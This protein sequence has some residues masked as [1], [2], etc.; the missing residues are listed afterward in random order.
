MNIRDRL[1][2]LWDDIA[3]V[4]RNALQ[5]DDVIGTGLQINLEEGMSKV[6]PP[7]I[8]YRYEFDFSGGSTHV[9]FDRN[10]LSN[11]VRL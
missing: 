11:E 10:N 8:G 7:D 5:F 6:L 3:A 2:D 9:F 4:E 1:H